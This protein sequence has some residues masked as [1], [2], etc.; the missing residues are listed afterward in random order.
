MKCERCKKNDA[1]VY[2]KE[3]VNGIT[4]EYHLC[5]KCFAEMNVAGME[6]FSPFKFGSFFAPKMNFS[7]LEQRKKCTLCGSSFD[8]VIREGKL[9]CSECYKVFER[10]LKPSVEKIHGETSYI[11]RK[12]EEK[13][14]TE[15]EI[16]KEKLN[17]AVANEEYEK[18][19][20]LRDKIKDKEAEE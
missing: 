12:K 19:A 3:T 8:D 7:P 6:D 2:Y 5:S 4:K 16:L 17:E 15:L 14:K 11:P 9:G 18:A 20:E 10:E 13:E 1:G